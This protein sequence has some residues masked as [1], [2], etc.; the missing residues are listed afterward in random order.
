MKKSELEAEN[1]KLRKELEENRRYSTQVVEMNA[2]L[3]AEL[4]CYEYYFE[5]R[6]KVV[7]CRNCI[8]N[9][10][11]TCPIAFIENQTLQ[12]VTH[13]PDFWCAEGKLRREENIK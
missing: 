11:A 6:E 5:H 3:K 8:Y 2:H 13:N 12:F 4:R 9:G 7:H 1:E 10:L